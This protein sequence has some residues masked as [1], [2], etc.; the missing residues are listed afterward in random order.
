MEK[1]LLAGKNTSSMAIQEQL[2]SIITPE[3][4]QSQISDLPYASFLPVSFTQNIG[5]FFLVLLFGLPFISIF[6]LLGSLLIYPI[7]II[8][9]LFQVFTLHTRSVNQEYFV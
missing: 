9:R 5:V 2:K 8:L 7:F 3:L 4:F 6:S 1:Q